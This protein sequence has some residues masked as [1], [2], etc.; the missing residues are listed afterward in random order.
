[1]KIIIKFTL[2]AL[3]FLFIRACGKRDEVVTGP[4]E[5]MIPNLT[6]NQILDLTRNERQELERRCL[7]SSNTTCIELKSELYTT[8]RDMKI[9]R[10]ETRVAF[11]D[12]ENSIS[13][14][15]DR[16]G[17]AREKQKCRDMF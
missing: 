1:M 8:L 6:V 17:L 2:A 5:S 7:G 12:L 9:S 4:K 3:V 11:K 10:C 15:P 14:A 13:L 16:E